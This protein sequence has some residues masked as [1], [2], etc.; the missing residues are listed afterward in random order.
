LRPP[1]QRAP[2]QR[3]N[4]LSRVPN[5]IAKK[6]RSFLEALFLNACPKNS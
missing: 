1:P 5:P 4:R 2:K 6:S 3:S